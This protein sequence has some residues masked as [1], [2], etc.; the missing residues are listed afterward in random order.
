MPNTK[1]GP[2]LILLLVTLLMLSAFI[3]LSLHIVNPE[4]VKIPEKPK[5]DWALVPERVWTEHDPILGWS[6]QKSKDAILNIGTGKIPMKFNSLG[7]RGS[8]EIEFKRIPGKKRVLALGD[9]FTFGWGVLDHET[10]S[11]QLEARN[12]DTE[13]INTGVPGYGID[14]I[15]LSYVNIGKKFQPDVVVVG[16]YPE[17]FWRATRA[18]SDTGYAKPYFVL[19]ATGNLTLKNSPAPP[20]FSLNTYQ[21]PTVVEKSSFETVLNHSYLYRFFY[22]R[23]LKLGKLL[24]VVDPNTEDEWKLGKAILRSLVAEIEQSGAKPLFF[25]IPPERWVKDSG[26]DSLL[27]AVKRFFKENK[28]LLI[29]FTPELKQLVQSSAVE[30][31]YIPQDL[32]WT[33]KSHAYVSQRLSQVLSENGYPLN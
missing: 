23:F 21:F 16:I 28:L 4:K 11:A 29:D 20:P 14:Q 6:L 19:T 7:F 5:S 1:L 25:I 3:E 8:T 17:D 2:N 32:H 12:P 10:F 15:Y 31:Y 13:V 27:T 33:A 18:F 24:G 22:K 26:G 30:D 9:S